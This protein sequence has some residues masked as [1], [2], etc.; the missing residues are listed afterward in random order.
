MSTNAA[1]L[2]FPEMRRVCQKNEYYCGPAVLD[3]LISPYGLSFDQDEVVRVLHAEDRVKEKG[4]LLSELAEAVKI[5]VPKHRLWYKRNSTISELST[6]VNRYELPVGV[7]WQGIF[8]KVTIED[9]AKHGYEQGDDDAGHYSVITGVD[10]ADD[11]VM[12]A[13]PFMN[14]GTDDQL[15][16]LEFKRRWWDINEIMSPKTHAVQEMDDYHALFVITEIDDGT[17]ELFHMMSE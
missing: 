4:L 9:Y 6:L 8:D 17:P 7:E 1:P 13:N 12:L 10:V 14:N 3:M 11:W 5:L 16:V 2:L 15:T